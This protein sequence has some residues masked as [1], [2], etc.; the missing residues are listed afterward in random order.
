MGFHDKTRLKSE[1]KKMEL[2]IPLDRADVYLSFS[3][4]IIHLTHGYP[5]LCLIEFRI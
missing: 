4:R 2:A 1:N 3:E 5:K